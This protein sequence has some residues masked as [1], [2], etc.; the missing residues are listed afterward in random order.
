M[1]HCLPLLALLAVSLSRQA[2]AA[3]VDG[4]WIVSSTLYG[5]PLGEKLTLKTE[6]EKVTG[7]LDQDKLTGTLTGSKL[8]LKVTDDQGGTTDFSGTVGKDAITGDVVR[9]DPDDPRNPIRSSFTARPMPRRPAGS[10]R[11]YDFKPTVYY[12][13][14]SAETKPVLRIWPGDTVH[15]T[16]VDATGVDELG[17]ARVL[18]GNPQTGPFFVE[19]AMPGD[20]LAVHFDRVRLNRDWAISDDLLVSRVLAPGLAVKVKDLGKT[21]RWRL[22]RERALAMP[23]KPSEH[24][25]KY[26]VP[27]RPMMG[28]V[29]LA[30]GFASAPPPTGDSGRYGGNMDLN[31][32]VEGTTVY[33]PVGQ[34]G[35][36]LYVGDGHAMQGDGELNGNALETSMEVEFTVTLLPG[37]SIP[38]P[39]VE[40]PT[41]LIAVGLAGSLDDA[42]R[43]ATSNAAGWLESDYQLTPSEVAQV[44]GTA[45][46][47][48]VNEVADRNVGIILSLSKQRLATLTG[49]AK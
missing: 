38:A 23:E 42:L 15:T 32:I 3:T 27:V 24:L 26:N 18:G 46:E 17:V 12:R 14:F 20:L 39:R 35:A 45:A 2:Q 1:R 25:S 28:C 48:R 40:S 6:G 10:P 43:Q 37:K 11:R 5:I 31:E 22:D 49:T 34:P 21:L 41:H 19:T 47:I 44:L 33:L 30:P 13:Q 4:E 16:T 8:T 29:G 9:N 7:T 36:L